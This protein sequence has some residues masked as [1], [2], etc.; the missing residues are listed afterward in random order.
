LKHG[1][2][3]DGGRHHECDR[4]GQSCLHQSLRGIILEKRS[5][6]KL[7]VAVGLVLTAALASLVPARRA[8]SVQRMVAMRSV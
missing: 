1:G 4:Q 6:K 8:A 3:E 7:G 2:D 5:W